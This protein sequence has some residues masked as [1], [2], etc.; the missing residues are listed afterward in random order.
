MAIKVIQIIKKGI[1][2]NKLLWYRKCGFEVPCL[3]D[4][5]NQVRELLSQSPLCLAHKGSKPK[6]VHFSRENNSF[7]FLKLFVLYMFFSTIVTKRIIDKLTI[8]SG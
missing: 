1:K 5:S 7:F 3:R 6:L 2:I 8:N 4:D